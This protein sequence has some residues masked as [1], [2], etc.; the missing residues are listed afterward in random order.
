[1]DSTSPDGSDDLVSF[2]QGRGGPLH[3]QRQLSLPNLF[4]KAGGSSGPRLAQH[5]SVCLPSDHPAT[6]GY[7]ANQR[8]KMLSP[9]RVPLLED[10]ILVPR[11]DPA[12]VCSTMV[13]TTEERSS[14]ASAWQDLASPAGT[15]E[16]SCLAT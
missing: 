6:P 2:R 16:P 3:L 14:L 8:N 4:L 15:M 1:M 7:Q 9:P 5:P 11:D 13:N 12:A 10:P